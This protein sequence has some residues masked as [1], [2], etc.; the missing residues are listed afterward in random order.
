MAKNSFFQTGFAK[1]F[2]SYEGKI[3]AA[4]S[5]LLFLSFTSLLFCV[6]G[7][8]FPASAKF[9]FGICG[10]FF[11]LAVIG[12]LSCQSLLKSERQKEYDQI[13]SLFTEK[14]KGKADLAPPKIDAGTPE[15]LAVCRQYDLFLEKIRQLIS[16]MRKIGID[17]AVDST[18][19]ASSIANTVQKTQQQS[20]I[21]TIVSAASGEASQ[22]IS[23]VSENTQYVSEKTTTNL[24]MA[25][26]SLEEITDITEKIKRIHQTVTSFISTVEELGNNSSGIL[27]IINIINN[28]SEQTNLLSLN[29][30]IEAARAG[31]H[32]KG[33]AIVAQEVRELSRRIAPATEQITENINTMI[34]IVE[35]TQRETSQILEYSEET[36]DVVQRTTENFHALISDF[37]EADNQLMKI[38]AAIEE[39]STNNAEVSE[40]VN[41]INTLSGAITEEMENSDKSVASLHQMTEKMLEMVA[42][43]TTGKGLFDAIIVRADE[44]RRRYEKKI[45]ELH[46][47][48]VNVFDSNYK[49]VPDTSP[50]K[51]E[52]SFTKAFISDMQPLFEED[53]ST[54]AGSIYCLTVDRNGYIPAHHK[55]VSQPMTGDPEKDL[56]NSRHQRI[57]FSNQ[58]EKRRA[59]NTQPLLLQTYMR[60]TG[61]ILNDLSMPL[62]INGRHWGALIIGL[63]PETLLKD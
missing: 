53:K 41:T 10:L 8:L 14:E 23:E 24:S 51:F 6:L 38:A 22:A 4:F 18:T 20:D 54:I 15:T 19:V 7:V 36:N 43:F 30:T 34:N 46:A 12:A 58:T 63:P 3:H 28:I 35:K 29:A 59:T 56:L 57:Y 5:L 44:I 47:K 55:A 42:S 61:E 13:L 49:K 1:T 40:K 39:L 9:F 16:E 32:G 11:V 31:E 25:K 37:E 21:S 62:Y 33:F 2:P 27:E 17:I 60:D 52:T 48:G 26:N 45:T 50:Q